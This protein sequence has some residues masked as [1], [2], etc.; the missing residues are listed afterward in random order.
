MGIRAGSE[1]F[2]LEADAQSEE[3]SG[4]IEKMGVR[5]SIETLGAAG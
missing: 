4:G 5:R 1:M 3:G 2:L